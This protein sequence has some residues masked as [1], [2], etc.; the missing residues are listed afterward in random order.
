MT[1]RSCP[2]REPIERDLEAWVDRNFLYLA[3]GMWL[4]VVALVLT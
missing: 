1:N 4:V 2:D 3:V